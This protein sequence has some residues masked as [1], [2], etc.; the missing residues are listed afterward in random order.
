MGA[1]VNAPMIAVANFADAPNKFFY[2]YYEDLTVESTLKILDALKRGERPT[3]GPQSGRKVAMPAGGKT[4]L[5]EK[6]PGPYCRP[7]L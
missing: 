4:T 2:D 3:P 5:L 7:D 1:C 6:P